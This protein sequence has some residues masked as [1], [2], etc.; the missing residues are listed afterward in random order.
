MLFTPEQ[1]A[2]LISNEEGTEYNARVLM[3]TE[4]KLLLSGKD[5]QVVTKTF[6][7]ATGTVYVTGSLLTFNA[8]GEIT[9][10]V[11]PAAKNAA[12]TGR[13]TPCGAKV[14]D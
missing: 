3:S 4:H 11:E 9:F 13:Q 14:H 2:H 1:L 6:P 8:R 12:K 7:G 5:E 10:M